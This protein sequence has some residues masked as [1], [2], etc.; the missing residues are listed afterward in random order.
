[1]TISKEYKCVL[2][3]CFCILLGVITFHRQN[4]E[5]EQMESVRRHIH[6]RLEMPREGFLITMHNESGWQAAK[7]LQRVFEIEKMHVVIGHVGHVSRM[8]MYTRYV[9]QTGRTDDLQ[10]GNLNML[11]CIETH[12]EVWA[13]ISNTSY[14]FEHDAS[15]QIINLSSSGRL[16]KVVETAL[17]MEVVGISLQK[18]GP[19][20]YWITTT[21]LWSKW[22]PT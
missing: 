22:T 11:G 12:R 7:E 4:M 18:K 15:H 3:V 17:L 9:M 6:L 16:V 8:P 20:Y 19:R 14:V 5:H 13:R 10:I 1:M 2:V 21:H